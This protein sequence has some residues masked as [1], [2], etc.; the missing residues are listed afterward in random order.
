MHKN[1]PDDITVKIDPKDEKILNVLIDNSRL[2]FRAI[3]KKTGLSTATVINHIQRLKKEG[4][5]LKYTTKLDYE[6][7]GYDFLAIIEL[8]ISHGQFVHV[9][10][11]ISKFTQV[12]SMFDTTGNF[13]SVVIARFKSRRNLDYFLK[14]ILEFDEIERSSTRIVLNTIKYGNFKIWKDLNNDENKNIPWQSARFVNLTLNKP[15]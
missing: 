6:K 9:E 1:N 8:R 13:D 3:A 12:V 7:L 5:I 14:K 2:S 4:I 11:K 15:F 10:E